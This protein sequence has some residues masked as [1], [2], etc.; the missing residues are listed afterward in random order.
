LQLIQIGLAQIFQQASEKQS[1]SSFVFDVS[2]L[3]V[4]NESIRDLLRPH[5]HDELK[6]N[7]SPPDFC[8]WLTCHAGQ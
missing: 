1:D 6:V 3:E 4:Y 2:V 8:L 5:S 7:C